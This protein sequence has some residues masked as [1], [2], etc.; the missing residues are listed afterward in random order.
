MSIVMEPIGMI[1]TP[2]SVPGD[3]PRN[4]ADARGVAA[5]VVVHES[6]AAGLESIDGFSHL[7]LVFQF[8]RSEGFE[9]RFVPPNSRQPRGVFATRS[10]FRPNPI[11]LSVVRL[12]RREAGVLHVL[13]ADIVDGSPLL[14]IKPYLPTTDA[15]PEAGM[16]WLDGGSS[17][18]G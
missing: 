10:P 4:T 8:H 9:L 3:M 11:G 6:W 16:G 2:F 17:A 15:H 5:Q 13:D 18:R 12:E 7:I 14:D 1:R